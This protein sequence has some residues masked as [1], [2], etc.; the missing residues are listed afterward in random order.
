MVLAR[1]PLARLA[2]LAL[3]FA[4]PVLPGCASLPADGVARG[5][6]LYK[7]CVQCHM[8]DG[9]GS[10]LMHAPQIAGLPA[11]Y[12]TAQVTHFQHG[13]RGAHPDDQAGLK[14][15]P[16]SR[17][18]KS[19]TDVALVAEYVA[20]LPH[21]KKAAR[22]EGDAAKGQAA[23]AT[24]AACHGADGAGN[25]A[26]K[27]PPIRQLEDWYIALQ[28]GKFKAGVRGYDPSDA[29]GNQMGGIAKGLADTSAMNDLAA[30]VQTLPA[31]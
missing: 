16:M 17:T 2:L 11:W 3:A 12:I 22:V 14:M 5:E 25:E 9:Q 28:L 20:S 6:A 18:L 23:F 21:V 24:C 30:Y 8:A 29:Q 15:R 19:D 4:G 31:Q 7:N 27:A 26:L 10:E 13:V 1:R